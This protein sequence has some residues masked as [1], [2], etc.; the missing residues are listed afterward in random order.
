MVRSLGKLGGIADIERLVL[1]A[2][3]GAP[4]QVRDVARVEQVPDER[5][6]IAERIAAVSGGSRSRA[7][8]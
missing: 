6:G 5:R 4:V 8:T 7:G 2:E 1:K 3:A